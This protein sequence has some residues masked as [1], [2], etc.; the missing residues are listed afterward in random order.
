MN[1]SRTWSL[2]GGVLTVMVGMSHVAGAAE[3]AKEPAKETEKVSATADVQAIQADKAAFVATVDPSR[4]YRPANAGP[5]VLVI[6][7]V[8]SAVRVPS[9]GSVAVGAVAVA[10]A[11]VTFAAQ[12]G[13]EFPNQQGAITIVADKDGVASTIFTAT[14]GTVAWV[15]IVAASPVTAGRA[16]IAV[17]VLP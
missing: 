6:A 11:A 3:T 9:G 17:Q 1:R 2:I 15:D 13:G 7:P 10:G 14:K 8:T 16:R 12:N 5:G 4:V